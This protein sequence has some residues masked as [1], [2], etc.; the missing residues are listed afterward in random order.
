MKNNLDKTNILS[1]TDQKNRM[2][3]LRFLLIKTASVRA[4][5][6]PGEL[7]RVNHYYPAENPQSAIVCL[8]QRDILTILNLNYAELRRGMENSLILFYHPEQLQETLSRPENQAIIRRYGYPE[9]K[10]CRILI[11]RLKERFSGDAMP[12]E[13]GVFVGY[14]AKDVTGFI[15]RQ[16]R[17]P[18]MRGDWA[19]FGDAG[20][21]LVRMNLYLQVE[22]LAGRILD[23][24]D[25][26]QTFFEN[27]TRL[28]ITNRRRSNG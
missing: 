1:K 13:V 3:P 12:H 6:K 24:C 21:S 2:E 5:V 22:S 18:V 27:I 17:T 20:E 28:N 9:T 15:S 16:P 11:R 4:G 23:V 14:P 26:L 10:D 8:R 25:D 19:V 7:L